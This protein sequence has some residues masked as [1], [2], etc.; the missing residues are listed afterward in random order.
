MKTQMSETRIHILLALFVAACLLATP[1]SQTANAAINLSMNNQEEPVERQDAAS[2]HAQS[3]EVK[4][5]RK[6][7]ITVSFP[8][9]GL[10]LRGWIY[11]PQGDGPFPA[12]IWNHGSEKNPVPHPELGLFYTSHGYVLFLPVRHGHNPSPGEHISDMVNAFKAQGRSKD[13]VQQYA[14]ELQDDYNKD[15]IAAIKWLRE[16]PYVDGKRV[17]V[18]GCSYGGIQ[19][20]LTAEK[21]D[22]LRAAVAFAPGAMSWANPKLQK[23]EKEA[24]RNAS[25]PL[26]LIQASNDYSTGP[27]EV[28]GPIIRS[29]GGLNRATLYPAFGTTHQE[30]HGGFACWEEGITIWGND[31]LKFLDAAGV[32]PSR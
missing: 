16:Q 25:I 11:R 13:E 26:F 5:F 17:V 24:V 20:L 22:G 27:S 31:V 4:A 21:G 28:L 7:A 30:G 3:S 8:S 23:R 32:G 19:T 10:T 6:N 12:I 18:S 15:V 1:S 2:R 14:V 9:N 29:K